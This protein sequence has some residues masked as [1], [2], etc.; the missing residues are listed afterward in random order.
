M[1]IEFKKIVLI[2]SGQPSLNPRIVK[3]ANALAEAGYDVT[4]IYQFWNNWAT[5]L[6]QQLLAK[7]K[8]KAIRVGGDPVT[9]KFIYWKTR[10]QYKIYQKLLG[11]IG[12]NY[13]T[14][15]G[16]IGRCTKLLIKEAL[17]T[18]AEIYIA[19]NLSAL[20]AAV[21][22][23]KKNN[24]KCGFDAEDFH[25][26]EV[27]DDSNHIEFK[28]KKFIE[29]HFIDKIDYLTTA[30]PLISEAYQQLYSKINPVT[31]LN[32]FP[33]TNLQI[34][35]ESSNRLK[36]FWFSQTIGE[37]RGIEQIILAIGQLKHQT[38]ELHLLG[39]HSL[40]IKSKFEE[41]ALKN[42]LDSSQ[43]IFHS[44]ISS[45]QLIPF[46]SQFDIGIASEIST[47]WNRNICL[48]NKIFTYINAGLG[49]LASD[50]LAQKK[51]LEDYPG[52]G[53]I[54]NKNEISTLIDCLN[55][56]INQPEVLKNQKKQAL[57]YCNNH[58]NWE[59]E[60]EKFLNIIKVAIS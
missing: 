21:I 54:Y 28:L 34:I 48:T 59:I 23:A 57:S 58:L 33:K 50:T 12:L 26:N 39:S 51:L 17:K 6:D 9:E 27:T 19:H 22:A 43:L 46:A 3:E 38:I 53:F 35:K 15:I 2:T 47:P 36:L 1:A 11:L 10:V 31:I 5:Q 24:C 30:S 49:V 52:M 25:R 56:Y 13:K 44:P 20:P 45:D 14:S 4:V 41:I 32:V 60:K 29:D 7:K 18:P 40:E 8:W 55:T 42:N 16:A 37:G